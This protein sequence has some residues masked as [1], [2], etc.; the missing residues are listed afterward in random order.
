MPPGWEPAAARWDTPVCHESG[1]GTRKGVGW[2]CRGVHALEA[3][4]HPPQ[5]QLQEPELPAGWQG[6][7]VGAEARRSRGGWTPGRWRCA[8]PLPHPNL[9]GDASRPPARAPLCPAELRASVT[10]SPCR[11][12]P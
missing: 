4:L 10:V 8:A 1:G 3:P 7:K 11:H 9:S 5:G 6:V 12:V 2:G